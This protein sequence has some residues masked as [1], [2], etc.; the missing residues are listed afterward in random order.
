MIIEMDTRNQKDNYVTDYFDK[1]GIKWIRNKLYS[2][3][4]KLLNDTKIII[5]LKANLEE[6]AHNL[7]NSQE[8]ARIHRELDRAREIGCEQFIFLIKE[9]KIKTIQDL[10]NWTSKRTKVKGEVLLKIFKTMSQKYRIRFII[11]K[12]RK[13]GEMIINLLKRSED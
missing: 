5:D 3:D 4:V 10:Q 7:C 8:H 1:K 9:D 11:C 6:I 12:K 13:I 2:G